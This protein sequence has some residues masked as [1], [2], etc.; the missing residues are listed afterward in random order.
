MDWI[1][2][3]STDDLPQEGKYVLARHNLDTWMDGTDQKNVNCVVVKLVKGL[4]KTD[5][6][7][8]KNGEIPLEIDENNSYPRYERYKFADEDGNNTVP[9]RWATFGPT[10]FFGKDI[11]EW[12]PIN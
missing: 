5:R 4:S 6:I 3:N 8:M 11:V 12:A 10:S 2:I 1:K 9:Y 7:K